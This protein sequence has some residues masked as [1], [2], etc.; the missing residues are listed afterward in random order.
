MTHPDPA[1]PLNPT[2]EGRR[3][4]RWTEPAGY[5][6]FSETERLPCRCTVFCARGC[7]GR[8]GCEACRVFFQVW[9]DESGYL[10]LERDEAGE[11]REIPLV[12]RAD[13][14]NIMDSYARIFPARD[15]DLSGHG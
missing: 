15:D 10:Q 5:Y 6:V 7:D 13:Y 1:K 3:R 12:E 14:A 9:A 8:C 4:Y 11:H 2:Q